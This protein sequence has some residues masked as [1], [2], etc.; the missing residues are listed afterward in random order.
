MAQRR[1]ANYHIL[2]EVASGGQGTVYSA[3]DARTGE[4]VALKVMHPHLAKD[5]TYLERF[6]R[7]AQLAASI[8]HPNVI[9]IF[10][11]GQEGDSHF[12]SMEYLPLTANVLLESQRQPPISRVVDI[13]RQVALAAR[14]RII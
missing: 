8:R 12:I 11:V 5:D 4:V 2:E 3:R 13:C 14:P 6:H 9:R 10:E 7:E 1:I